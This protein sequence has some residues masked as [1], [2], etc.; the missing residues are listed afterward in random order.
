MGPTA[1]V[2]AASAGA[3][4]PADVFGALGIGGPPIEAAMALHRWL[5]GEEAGLD[6]PRPRSS[7]IYFQPEGGIMSGHGVLEDTLSLFMVQVRRG[8][9]GEG[10]GFSVTILL[11]LLSDSVGLPRRSSSSQ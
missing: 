10:G 3:T 11:T 9:E 7:S 8:K 1:G 2:V 5:Q 6:E 4:T